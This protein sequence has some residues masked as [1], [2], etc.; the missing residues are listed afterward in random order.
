MLQLW[1]PKFKNQ[2]PDRP[3]KGTIDMRSDE[4]ALR[5]RIM[6][7]AIDQFNRKGLKFT[8]DDVAGSLSVS[9]KTLYKVF[10]DKEALFFDMVDYCFDAIKESERAILDDP[11]MDI[12]EKIRKIIIVLPH[13]YKTIDFRQLYSLREKFPLIY[14]RLEKRLESDWEP[15]ISLLEQGMEAGRIKPLSTA[16]LRAMIEGTIEHFLSRDILL[17]EDISYPEALE[18]MMDI[19]MEG[20]TV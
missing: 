13:R 3:Q 5:E 18:K 1:K 20:I 2:F 17:Q 12:V 10:S 15:T 8:M 9:K 4:N 6:E 7:A 16:V 14:A 19:I 11:E